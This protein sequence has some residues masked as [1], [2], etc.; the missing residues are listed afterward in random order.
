MSPLA[1]GI[2]VGTTSVK[3]LALDAA[4]DVVAVA[5]AAHGILDRAG[6]VEAS[7]ARWWESTT[8][9]LAALADRLGGLEAVEVVG[10]SGNMSSVVLVDNRGAPVRDAVLLA[11]P[12][13]AGQLA[14]L[15]TEV[16]DALT[17]ATHNPLTTVFSLATLLWL[18]DA[19]PASLDEAAAWLSAKDYVRLRLTGELATEITDAANSLLVRAGTGGWDGDLIA[20]VGLDNGMFPPI[21][22][23]SAVAGRVRPGTALRTGTPVVAG[24]GDMA[25]AALGAGDPSPGQLLVSLGTSVTAIAHLG[26]EP[27]APEWSGRLTYHPLPAG[28]GAFALA[29]LLTGGLAVNWLRS[30][31]GTAALSAAAGRPDPEDPLVFLPQL[32]GGGTPDFVGALRGT[33]FGVRPSTTGADIA[34]AVYEAVA[35]ELAA[36]ADLLGE[37]HVRQL[38]L[39]GGGANLPAWTSVITDVLNR[40]S[41]TLA[42]P[43]ASAIGA[44]RLAWRALGHD[45]PAGLAAVRQDPRPEHAAAWAHRRAHYERARRAAVSYY[46]SDEQRR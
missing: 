23:S 27:F 25:A 24:T 12:R 9:A 6:V 14:A 28:D 7:P 29:S 15:P 18:R 43:D 36:V 22:D 8:A 11:D 19:E 4:G 3:V 17:S 46:L 33:L 34:Q 39:T 30:L 13:G 35:F 10:L 38:L 21:V 37:A 2:D 31:A 40:P 44:A 1:V 16:R 20:A 41:R 32:A 42:T 5:S 26:A 45:C